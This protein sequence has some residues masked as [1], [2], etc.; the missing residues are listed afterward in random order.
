MT[1]DLLVFL[2]ITD[3]SSD[4]DD[5]RSGDEHVV[6][7][8]LDL[9]YTQSCADGQNDKADNHNNITQLH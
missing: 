6:C 8:W 7:P 9:G 3:E 2:V 4:D 1:Y 5:R